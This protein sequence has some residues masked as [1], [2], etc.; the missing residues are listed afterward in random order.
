MPM[1]FAK[2][3]ARHKAY[4]YCGSTTMTPSP[5]PPSCRKKTKKKRS[6]IASLMKITR[7]VFTFLLVWC[8]PL[9]LFS[10]AQSPRKSAAKGQY[11]VYVGTYT[12]KTES[13][14]IYAFQFDAATGEMT[15]P[16]LAAE[17][18]DPSFVAVHPDGKYLYA[19]N[20]AG[21]NSMV[22]AFAIDEA[23]GKLTLLNQLPALGKDPCYIS[24][25][26]AG[27]YVLVANYTSGNIVVFPILPG[28]KLGE[29]TALVQVSGATGP[30]KE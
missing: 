6:R 9:V 14:G 17:S 2:R 1:K 11:L 22:S 13:K 7:R 12:T 28:G 5:P 4:A 30:N 25:D 18:P 16:A 27:K 24:F 10:S 23:S 3:A 21:K 19:V 26:K 29:H 20:E 15:A 8:A